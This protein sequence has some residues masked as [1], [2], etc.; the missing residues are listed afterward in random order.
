MRRQVPGPRMSRE[1]GSVLPARAGALDPTG[2]VGSGRQRLRL[3]GWQPCELYLSFGL[4]PCLLF[5]FRNSEGGCV[6]GSVDDEDAG[7]GKA[8]KKCAIAGSAG[9]VGSAAGGAAIGGVSTAGSLGG[10]PPTFRILRGSSSQANMSTVWSGSVAPT[11][12]GR[13][14]TCP[15]RWRVGSHSS[16]RARRLAGLVVPQVLVRR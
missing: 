10:P 8:A 1:G 11:G 15:R 13:W 6:G 16:S 3:R 9:G 12:R 14:P 7:I 4:A 5:G 2:P